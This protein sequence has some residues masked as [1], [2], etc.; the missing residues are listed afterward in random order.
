MNDAWIDDVLSELDEAGLR[1][2][3]RQ[4]DAPPG[5]EMTIDGR[6]VVQFASNDYLSLAS[7]PRLA[8]AVACAGRDAGAGATASRLIVGTHPLVTELEA[9]L[10]ELKHTEAALVLPTGYMAN[11]AAVTALVGRGDAIVAD[12]LCH[13][14]IL[15]AAAL[16][17]A[18]LV[19]FDHNDAASLAEKLR[20]T[21]SARRQLVVTESVF[22]MDGDVAPLGKLA[23][24]A[25]EHGAMFIVDEAHATGVFGAVGTGMAEELN[26][27]AA[28]VTA[29]V[30]TLSKALGGLGGFVSAS[31]R[32]VELMI[33]TS[34]SFIFTTGIAPVQA[35]AALAALEIVR[36]EPERRARLRRMARELRARLREIGP[37]W[38]RLPEAAGQ[39]PGGLLGDANAESP[40]IP[41][42]VGEAARA[43]AMSGSLWQRGIFVPA[44]RPPTVPRGTSRLR[45][46]L[47]SGHTDEQVAQLVAALSGV[48]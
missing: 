21:R 37:A 31:R 3:L 47:Q 6:R 17:R 13:A 4:A 35:A 24:V 30:G 9:Q 19:R 36:D 38:G 46:S 20:A 33:N 28:A 15:D 18:R 29:T 11:L 10:A 2:R 5:P 23:R 34:R 12:R 26:V 39:G 14:S 44:I 43:V 22:S 7:D 48:R 40:I 25:A 41:L 42:V 45:V 1:R 32:V 16:S 8:E 27:D